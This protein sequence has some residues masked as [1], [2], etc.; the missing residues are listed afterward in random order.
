MPLCSTINAA[1]L[2]DVR[3]R[4][5]HVVEASYKEPVDRLFALPKFEYDDV[6]G[7]E[8]CG[9]GGGIRTLT[10][11]GLSALPLPIGLRPRRTILDRRRSAEQDASWPLT[12][13]RST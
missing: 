10:W 8:V 3:V 5:G 6:V 7:A 12:C 4:D 2:D 11:D 13:H 1:V 9:G